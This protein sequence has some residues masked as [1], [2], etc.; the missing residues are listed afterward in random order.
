[1][2]LLLQINSLLFFFKL[3]HTDQFF[4]AFFFNATAHNNFIYTSIQLSYTVR[5]YFKKRDTAQLYYFFYTFFKKKLTT[6]I[7]KKKDFK[8]A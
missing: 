2:D 8:A 5:Y 7:K 4:T 1:M 3:S 6:E